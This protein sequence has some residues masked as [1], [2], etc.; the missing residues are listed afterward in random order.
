MALE[1]LPNELL[2]GILSHLKCS[3]LASV[4]R[5]SRHLNAVAEPCLYHTVTLNSWSKPGPSPFHIVLIT[6]LSRPRVANHIR[7]L[8]LHWHSTPNVGFLNDP[9]PHVLANHFTLISAAAA[10]GLDN[11]LHSEEAQTI[12]LLHLI[13]RLEVLNLMPPYEHD[14][15]TTFL[16]GQ[17]STGLQSLREVKYYWDTTE[18]GVNPALL[19]SLFALPAIRVLDVYFLND[20]EADADTNHTD[21]LAHHI[22]TSTV[23]DLRFGYGDIS[24]WAFDLILPIPRALTHFTY[25]AGASG[26]CRRFDSARFGQALMSAKFTLQS[27]VL[28]FADMA[29]TDDYDDTEEESPLLTIGSLRDWPALCRIRCSLSPLLGKER[30]TLLQLVDVLPRVIR[31]FDVGLDEFWSYGETLAK[32]C[33]MVKGRGEGGLLQLARVGVPVWWGVQGQLKAVCDAAGV[34]VV[35]GAG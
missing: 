31:E 27:L 1:T 14:L 26:S 3:D 28:C 17:A 21:D 25:G 10:V 22:G 33:E 34:A 11:P 20:A 23:T 4:S 9:S 15:L 7:D 19:L 29:D 5:V 2:A 16:Q 30:E 35:R 6:L 12:L 13:P 18:N 32:V 24:P 8:G